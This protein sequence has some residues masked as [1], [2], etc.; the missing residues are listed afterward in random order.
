MKLNALYPTSSKY[1]IC[2]SFYISQIHLQSNSLL[3]KY[4][5]LNLWKGRRQI[6][7][8]DIL[9]RMGWQDWS[10]GLNP[11]RPPT[12]GVWTFSRASSVRLPGTTFQTLVRN[13]GQDFRWVS[14]AVWESRFVNVWDFQTLSDFLW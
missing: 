11:L 3:K 8:V 4:Q 5:S 9:E 2:Q 7:K 13:E 10:G 12:Q 14:V 6:I 1:N